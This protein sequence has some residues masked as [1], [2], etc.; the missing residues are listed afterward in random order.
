MWTVVRF[1]F[2]AEIVWVGVRVATKAHGKNIFIR[3]M[4]K[5]SM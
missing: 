3:E 5:R 2:E 4:L 1:P